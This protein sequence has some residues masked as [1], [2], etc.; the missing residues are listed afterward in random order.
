MEGRASSTA[1]AEG[2]PTSEFRSVGIIGGGLMGS[3]IAEVVA[4]AGIAAT[5]VEKTPDLAERAAARIAASLEREVAKDRLTEAVRDRILARV[6]VESSLEAAAECDLII[7][8]VT[9]DFDVKRG[10]F[11]RLGKLAPESAALASNT[12]SIPISPLAARVPRPERVLG[13]HFFA[14]APRMKLVEVVKT[15]RTDPRVCDRIFRFLV[16]LSA[17]AG[18]PPRAPNARTGRGASGPPTV[19]AGTRIW[20]SSGS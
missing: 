2:R 6:A 12:S 4:S 14:P 20:T 16:L 5:L 15:L 1:Q 9:E 10:L 3:G 11:S 18:A 7:E 17:R 13:V 19:G 8:A